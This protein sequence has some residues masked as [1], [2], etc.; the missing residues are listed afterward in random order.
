MYQKFTC[1]NSGSLS[2]SPRVPNQEFTMP[3]SHGS[4]MACI[5]ELGYEDAYRG[6]LPAMTDF[7]RQE[8]KYCGVRRRDIMP[9]PRFTKII[10]NYFLSKHNSISKTHGLKYNTSEDDGVLGMLKKEE[11]EELSELRQRL[12]RRR[13][14]LR[15]RRNWQRRKKK[16]A[17]DQSQKLKGIEML[18]EAVHLEIDTQKAIK[19]SR[20]ES[21]FQ[22]QSGGSSEGV[23]ITPEVPDEPI[24]KSTISDEGAG[25][26]LDVL[27]ETKDKSKAQDDLDDWGSTNDET[28]LFG[29]ND[30]PVE[31]IP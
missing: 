22:H 13:K 15:I 12:F 17:I 9:Y 28:F 24:G 4:L 8:L 1:S 30:E 19:T 18:S 7:D 14:L 26:S 27:D 29:D 10:I 23:G 5:M 16:K 25:I 6:K 31:E 2:Q 20:R 3:P 11:A 21:I